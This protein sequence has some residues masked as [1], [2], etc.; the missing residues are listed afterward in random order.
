M[1]SKFLYKKVTYLTKS[2]Y[3]Q[4]NIS[5]EQARKKGNKGINNNNK[6]KMKKKSRTHSSFKKELD[7]LSGF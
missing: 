2:I 6:R 5:P 4:T 3:I 7:R 1:L